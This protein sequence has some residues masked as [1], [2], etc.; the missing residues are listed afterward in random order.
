M[1]DFATY[2]LA[3]EPALPW[4]A[5]TFLKAY[6]E[7]RRL[8]DELAL[9]ASP[10]AEFVRDLAK[11]EEPWQGTATELLFSLRAT[12]VDTE[13]LKQRSF[14]KNGKVLSGMLR[15][16]AP[17]LANIGVVVTF[18]KSGERWIRIEKMQ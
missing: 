12:V 17:N 2:V 15:R 13:S 5:G 4:P 10:I 8:A 16:L 11:R 3:A 7:N 6:T 18:G 1:A 9:E 14:P